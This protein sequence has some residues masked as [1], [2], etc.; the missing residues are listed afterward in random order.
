MRVDKQ[1]LLSELH[2]GVADRGVAVG[3]ILHGASHDVRHFVEATVV[4][5]LHCVQDAP[6]HGFQTVLDVGHGAFQNHV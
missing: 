2:E 4:E 5:F 3:V 1:F 6:L